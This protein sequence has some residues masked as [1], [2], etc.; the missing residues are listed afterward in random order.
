MISAPIAQGDYGWPFVTNRATQQ[1]A[2]SRRYATDWARIGPLKTLGVIT[3]L[4][5]Y[6]LALV[7]STISWQC[8]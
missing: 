7:T 3:W 5:R 6:I 8:H 2:A 1:T 4:C